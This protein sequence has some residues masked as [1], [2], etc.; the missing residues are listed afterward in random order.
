MREQALRFE[1]LFALHHSI[2]GGK[3]NA[4]NVQQ[5]FTP[6]QPDAPRLQAGEEGGI[7]RVK[8]M[9]RPLGR[10]VTGFTNA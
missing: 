8:E 3:Q 4:D 6:L 5:L 10:V 1:H 2:S 7:P 9:P